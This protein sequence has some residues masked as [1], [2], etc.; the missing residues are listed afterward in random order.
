MFNAGGTETPPPLLKDIRKAIT[1]MYEGGEVHQKG[2]YLVIEKKDVYYLNDICYRV[3]ILRNQRALDGVLFSSTTLPFENIYG[4]KDDHR[5]NRKMAPRK[6][7][8]VANMRLDLS[9]LQ[10]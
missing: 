7:S 3:T 10:H 2:N 5:L 1:L 8:I 4:L 6:A 9:K